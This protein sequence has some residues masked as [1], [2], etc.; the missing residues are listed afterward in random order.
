MP[1]KMTI[2][3]AV[4]E[5]NQK[6]PTLVTQGDS[7][8]LHALYASLCAKACVANPDEELEIRTHMRMAYREAVLA[9]SKDIRRGIYDG[10]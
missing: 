1:N 2:E 6:A 10:L 8:A 3:Q 4:A 9:G 5:F 7:E